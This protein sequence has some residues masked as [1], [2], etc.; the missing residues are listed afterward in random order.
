[1]TLTRR[2]LLYGSAVAAWSQD[3][4][5]DLWDPAASL[6]RSADLAELKDVRFSVIKAHE[7]NRDG[8]YGFLHGV[9]LVWHKGRL[10]ASFAHNKNP[11][12]TTGEEARWRVSEDGGQTWSAVFDVDKGSPEVAVSHGSFLSHRGKLWAFMGAFSGERTKV[13]TRSYL[14]DEKRNTW[15]PRGVI[16]RD[17]F[18][19]MQ[20][21]LRMSDGNWIMAGFDV[22]N[23]EPASVAI[24]RGDDFTKWDHKV[25]PRDVSVKKMWG[26]STVI[27]DGHRV[28]N[29]ARYGDE[30][31]ALVSHS[32]DGGRTWTA[33]RASNLPMATSKPYAGKL[34]NGQR[35]LVCT[36]TADSGGR[37]SPLT[38]AVTRPGER[39]F[40][41]VF[42]IRNAEHS[43][44]DS[45]PAARL[46]YP[47]AVEY[48]GYLYVGYSNSGG[49][50][51]NV[52]SAELAVVPVAALGA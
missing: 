10:Y 31:R 3:T 18:W 16:V 13:H 12:N 42:R 34:R 24:S 21:P 49:R 27:V 20:E 50:R 22:G 37:R 39:L 23:G 32:N 25:I 52:N 1:M 4:S 33:M 38:I 9:S 51:G 43:V 35:Y 6:P 48:Q 44:G 11:E 41:R 17:G 29:I 26:E 46:S 36:T 15:Q 8:G 45:H 30:A 19:P 28:L 5:E 14:L 47:Y 40:R 7:P 2:T